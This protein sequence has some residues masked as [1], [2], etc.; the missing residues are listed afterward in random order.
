MSENQ[1]VPV[2]ETTTTENQEV[3]VEETT[4][5]TT[6]TTENQEVP[7]EETTTTTTTTTEI[8]EVP[9]E[10]TSVLVNENDIIEQVVEIIN[11]PDITGNAESTINNIISNV[12]N[13]LEEKHRLLINQ[14]YNK[15]KD[16][17]INDVKG[18]SINDL[19][20]SFWMGVL[21]NV[22]IEVEKNFAEKGITKK[23]LV[24]ESIVLII[25]SDLLFDENEKNEIERNFRM[26]AP[27]LVETV[28]YASSN[29]NMQVVTENI[30]QVQ[31]CFSKLLKWFKN[32]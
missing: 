25:Q 16:Q 4:T 10:E 22:M 7:V 28:V 27:K 31:S 8:Q 17:I 30:E 1:E 14:L 21:V 32:K 15:F 12:D 26:I 20:F 24:I 19:D 18:K 9:V 11:V 13:K 3:S 29:L 2:E 6:T 5:T 23:D